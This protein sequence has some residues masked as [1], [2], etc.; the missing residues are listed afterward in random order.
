MEA[1]VD[2]NKEM[3]I[4]VAH[5]AELLQIVKNLE[6]KLESVNN[7]MNQLVAQTH[8]K[9][10]APANSN[11]W[12]ATNIEVDHSCGYAVLQAIGQGRKLI[13]TLSL[14]PKKAGQARTTILVEA[15]KQWINDPILFQAT[16]ECSHDAYFAKDACQ[17]EH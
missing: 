16:T 14:N 10:T 3:P 2:H 7:Q 11:S 5:Y 9:N 13:N 4:T 17:T 15:R 12:T 8:I 6:K 1:K